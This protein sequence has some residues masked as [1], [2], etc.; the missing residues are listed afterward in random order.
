MPTILDN[1]VSKTS[2]DLKKRKK[3]LH[4]NNLHSLEG[5]EKNRNSFKTALQKNGV[6]V[7]AEVKKGSPSKGI[8]REDFNPVDIALRY[9]DG[10]ASAISVL[11][12]EP[13]FKGD[14][15]YLSDISKRVEL[16]LLRKDFIIDP[17]QIKE[18]R[19]FGA[20]A[21]L[22]IMAIVS[23]AQLDELLAAGREFGLDALVECY[24]QDD[25]DRVPFD[26]VD[27]LGVNNRDL[28]N[29]EVDVHRG[30]SI[31]KQAPEDT[32]LVSESGISSGKDMAL[33]HQKSI[34]A[35]LIGE[36]FMRQSDPGKAVSLL[37]EEEEEIFERSL[38]NG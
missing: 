19:A 38:Q 10:G 1:I 5:F 15:Q 32:V 25:F 24:D 23:D 27:I 26:R 22:I 7:I 17:Y 9:Q 30:I 14:I 4:F 18:A 37:I 16:P 2:E 29:F 33:L 34:D 20:D 36:H 12:D 28:K 3:E 31:L 21:F 6:S 11:T 8:I 35:V 13:F